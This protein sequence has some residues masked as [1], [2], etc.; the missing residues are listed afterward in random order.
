MSVHHF[1]TSSRKCIDAM[2]RTYSQHFEPNYITTL[3]NIVATKYNFSGKYRSI[4][5][6]YDQQ[7]QYVTTIIDYD[8]NFVEYVIVTDSRQ[9]ND[10]KTLLK[11]NG[12]DLPLTSNIVADFQAVVGDDNAKCLPTLLEILTDV[13]RTDTL[14][15]IDSNANVMSHVDSK[16]NNF[17]GPQLY[18]LT[19]L[20]NTCNRIKNALLPLPSTES[21]NMVEYALDAFCEGSGIGCDQ[22]VCNVH[23]DVTLK[24][25]KIVSGCSTNACSNCKKITCVSPNWKMY[26][27]KCDTYLCWECFSTN[28]NLSHRIFATSE[29]TD[30]DRKI[31]SQIKCHMG[32]DLVK[33]LPKV[34]CTCD[35]CNVRIDREVNFYCGKCDYNICT[36]CIAN[37]RVINCGKKRVSPWCCIVYENAIQKL[38]TNADLDTM[39]D[40][41]Y[42]KTVNAHFDELYAQDELHDGE[43]I[44]VI[45][46]YKEKFLTSHGHHCISMLMTVGMPSICWCNERV[47]RSLPLRVDDDDTDSD[48]DTDSVSSSSFASDTTPIPY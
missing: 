2:L 47:C 10:V 24:I 43:Y 25:F 35:V 19:E 1:D 12:M 28:N 17:F 45:D 18:F 31:I 29:C 38:L 22:L 46:R 40:E 5:V 30:D 34:L 44:D 6:T 37:E 27:S 42:G 32:H 3:A 4:D 14:F 16:I 20:T 23:N 7:K 41:L 8:T 48:T 36:K 13:W 21:N 39:P 26:C 9:P 33:I 15:N 11:V